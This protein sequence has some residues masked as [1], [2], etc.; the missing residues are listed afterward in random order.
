M[1]APQIEFKQ[2]IEARLSLNV[3]DYPPTTATWKAAIT[4]KSS[5]MRY[6]SEPPVV[7]AGIVLFKWPSGLNAGEENK[8]NATIKMIVGTYDLEIY[9][10][11]H[12]DMG[13]V[14]GGV[15]V[16]SSNLSTKNA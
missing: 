7:D 6:E 3:S 15:R 9:L 1:A 5:N 14:Y 4:S 10:S 11:D 8:K 16:V 12:S 2:G 13:T